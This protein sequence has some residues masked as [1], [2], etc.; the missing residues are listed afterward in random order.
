IPSMNRP[1]KSS[2][3]AASA[4]AVSPGSLLQTLR[5]PVAATR[6]DVAARIGR[7]S[8]TFGEPPSQKAPYPSC[9]ASFAASAARPTPNGRQ[10]V[11]TPIFPMFTWTVCPPVQHPSGPVIETLSAVDHPPVRLRATVNRALGGGDPIE[12]VARPRAHDGV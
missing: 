2:R 11:Q 9:S 10:L 8:A 12:L 4:A 3:T 7:T 5:M 1:G 6:V